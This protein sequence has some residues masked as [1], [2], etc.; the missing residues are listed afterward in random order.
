MWC[1]VCYRKRWLVMTDKS[2]NKFWN[3]IPSYIK[4]LIYSYARMCCIVYYLS[5]EEVKKTMIFTVCTRAALVCKYYFYIRIFIAI[6]IQIYLSCF[7]SLTQAH[8]SAAGMATAAVF[9][10]NDSTYFFIAMQYRLS[11]FIY[12]IHLYSLAV[13]HKFSVQV[14]VR[15]IQ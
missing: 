11:I 4:S 10:Q 1:A 12:K 9:I 14:H 3:V 2:T 13:A 7:N 8:C 5:I 15:I 6:S